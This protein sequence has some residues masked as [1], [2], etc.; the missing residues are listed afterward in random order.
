V[1]YT[2]ATLSRTKTDVLT[3]FKTEMEAKKAAFSQVNDK[4]YCAVWY[5]NPNRMQVRVRVK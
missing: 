4:D 5:G 3:Y 2:Q 1:Y